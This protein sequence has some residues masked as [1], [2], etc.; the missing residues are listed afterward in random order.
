MTEKQKGRI[1][2]LRSKGYTYADIAKKL[3]VSVNTIKSF[4]RRQG[5]PDVTDKCQNCGKS[6]AQTEGAR[7]KKFCSDK[8]R[9]QWWNSHSDEVKKKAIYEFTCACCGTAFRAYGN[10]HRKYCSHDCYVK[11]RFEGGVHE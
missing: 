6:I 1:A 10:N 9:M 5:K 8:C 2:A 4:C 11:H 3:N 7:H